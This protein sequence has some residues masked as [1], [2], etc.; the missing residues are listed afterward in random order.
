MLVT[1]CTSYKKTSAPTDREMAAPEQAETGEVAGMDTSEGDEDSAPPS[2]S[3]FPCGGTGLVAPR[4]SPSN[5]RGPS[6]P[7]FLPNEAGRIP[8]HSPTSFGA[9]C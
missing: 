6:L 4:S 7:H 9:T 2:I 1:E 3:E 8:L 5:K